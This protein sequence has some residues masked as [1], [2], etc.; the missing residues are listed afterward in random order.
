V[1]SHI[2][3]AH[4]RHVA[5]AGIAHPGEFSNDGIENDVACIVITD[6]NGDGICIEG[7]PDDLASLAHR[8]LNAANGIKSDT[9]ADPQLRSL[10]GMV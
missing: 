1:S 7:P 4:A 6:R 3:W 5:V 10:Y 2:E 8:I 9:N